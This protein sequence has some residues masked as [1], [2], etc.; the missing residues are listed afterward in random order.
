VKRLVLV[1]LILTNP[2]TGTATSQAVP[3]L[4]SAASNLSPGLARTLD[5]VIEAVWSRFDRQQ[6][7]DHVRYISQ[8]WRVGGN[9]GYDQSLDRIHTRLVASGFSEMTPGVYSSTWFEE[10]PNQG[11]GWS[12]SAGTLAIARSGQADQV[13]LSRE[14][15]QIALCINSFSTADGGVVRP[16]VDVGRGDQE[17]D[18]AGK[19]VKG[20]VVLGDADPGALWRLAV[21]GHNAA[22]IVSTALGD[23]ISP[24]PPGAS[25]TPRDQWE[26]LQWG[27]IPYDEA[28][29]SFGFKA[30]P[31]AAATLRQALARSGNGER[32]MV[33]VTIASA[34]SR[35]PV[36]TLVAEIPGR[37]APGERVVIAAHVQEP[38]ANDNASGVATLAELARALS[39]AIRAG[40]VR[41][42]ERTITFLWLE[43]ITGSRQWLQRHQDLA[44]NIRDMFSLD[45]TGED[46]RK[47]G[48]SFLIERWPDPGA[49]W[50]RPWD[51]HTA[52]GR[53][54]VQASQLKGDLINDVH[55]AVCERVARRTG[56][57]VKT[58][59][60][61]GGSDHTVFGSA[62]VPA[63]L[64][65]HFTDRYYHTNLDA[66]DK[67][68]PDEMRNVGV[69]VAA[70]AW[71]VASSDETTAL[72]V[73]ALV[74]ASGHA[75]VSLEEQE[76][77]RLASGSGDE[78]GFRAKL[79]ESVAA[80]RKWYAEAVRS[81]SRLVVGPVSAR[82]GPGLEALARGFEASPGS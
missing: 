7:M 6:A 52:W 19:D 4:P 47:T 51:P 64:D 81:V 2:G 73:A 1:A 20:A 8:F 74:A 33:R 26:I 31:H 39:L 70:S 25:S 66:P 68:S 23:F 13:V 36:R 29:Q 53:G 76:G 71:L 65:W 3:A 48:G 49:V 14:K 21:A 22:G 41:Q 79:A 46:V 80:W 57:I 77:A 16:L 28:R 50:E 38:G 56:W 60:Y 17:A 18:Y 11:N 78:A 63:V 54:E 75:R 67:T 58:N 72:A 30:T 40:A 27:A 69:A 43:E 42:P 12:Y 61:E 24:D 32:V 44:A 37:T 59:P 82:F 55:L 35:K 10:Y 45:M 62:G 34:F 5:P 15:Q 9:P